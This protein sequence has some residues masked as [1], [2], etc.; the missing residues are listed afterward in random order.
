MTRYKNINSERIAFT[1]AEETA[2]DTEEK[3][4]VTEKTANQYRFDRTISGT[5]TYPQIPEQLDQLFKDIT[6]GKFGDDAKTGEWYIAIK[7]VK[8]ANPK[9]S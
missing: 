8:D 4:A 5:K 3:A 2:R 1:A 7:A 9:P 6:A